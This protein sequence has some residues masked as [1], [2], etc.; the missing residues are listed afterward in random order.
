MAAFW[1]PPTVRAP[2]E[3]TGLTCDTNLGS[4]NTYKQHML[5][6]GLNRAQ[7]SG[8]TDFKTNT[9]PP[10]SSFGKFFLNL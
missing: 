6:M 5:L 4:I 8:Q 10:G 3:L 1:I 2:Q 9:L 7:F